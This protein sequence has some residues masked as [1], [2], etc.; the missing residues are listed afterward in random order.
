MILAPANLLI[1]FI[2]LPK[3]VYFCAVFSYEGLKNGVTLTHGGMKKGSIA[4]LYGGLY[5]I[6]AILSLIQIPFLGKTLLAIKPADY[7]TALTF[8]TPSLEVGFFFIALAVF[9]IFLREGMLHFGRQKKLSSRNKLRRIT[10]TRKLTNWMAA[11]PLVI[12]FQY[13]LG[14][15][16]WVSIIIFTIFI[17]FAPLASPSALQ[18]ML[19]IQDDEKHLATG[20]IEVTGKKRAALGQKAHWSTFF[21]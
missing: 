20:H 13:L 21:R 10:K 19:P 5:L 18:K 9:I 3:L 12:G 1:Q 14:L 2:F 17:Y 11:L 7:I 4:K 15:P 6:G 8:A 16:E